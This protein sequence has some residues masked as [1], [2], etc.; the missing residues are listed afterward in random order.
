MRPFWGLVVVM[1]VAACGSAASPAKHVTAARPPTPSATPT[2]AEAPTATPYQAPPTTAP[3]YT[4]PQSASAA[5]YARLATFN[6]RIPI[7]NGQPGS[8]GFISIPGGTFASDPASNV[9]LDW[10]GAPPPK[11]PQQGP[12][13]SRPTSFG[14]S[15]DRAVGRWLPVGP[16]W[17]TPDGQSY[18]Y[19]D[20]VGGGV[21]WVKVA[22]GSVTTLGGS[23]SWNLLDVETEGAYAVRT[24]STG[25][26]PS[27]LWLLAPG[28]DPVQ[29]IGSGYWSWVTTGF[30]YGYDAPSVPAGAPHPLLRFNLR[31]HTTVTW[32][33]D[34]NQ[35]QWVP[36]F[37]R[38]GAPI[39]VIPPANYQYQ[40]SFETALLAAPD[41]K[42]T[43][44]KAPQG[45][46]SAIQ[47]AHGYWL[48]A[49]QLYF[50]GVPVSAVQG[51]LGGGC[52]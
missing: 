3:V 11:Q 26:A 29:V 34:G 40:P 37:D 48:A 51:Q 18:A 13:P 1:L 46:Q 20:F 10:T 41:T 8:G 19:P 5:T 43:L 6:C 36:G 49:D 17:V 12:G 31:D 30:A 24:D 44:L 39:V 25:Q 16:T 23:N 42:N 7:S 28:K 38:G 22:D 27:G 15:F 52:A 32:Y 2:L 9:V 45:T 50:N 33:Q 35:V 21:R 47:D 14:L 4:S